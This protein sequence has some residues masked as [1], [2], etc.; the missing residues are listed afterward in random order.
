MNLILEK[1][2]NSYV[3]LD[4]ERVLRRVEWHEDY[5]RHGFYNMTC[6]HAESHWSKRA[7][8]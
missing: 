3:K 7:V 5:R 4:S 2:Q 8:V 6:L 1:K